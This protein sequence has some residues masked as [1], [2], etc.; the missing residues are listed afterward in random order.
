MSFILGYNTSSPYSKK[1]PK[2][3]YLVGQVNGSR[4]PSVFRTDMKVY[5]NF[6]LNKNAKDKSPMMLQVY[7]DVFN[8]FNTLN[9]RRV[10]RETGNANDDAYLTTSRNEADIE[11][12]IDETAYRNYYSMRLDLNEMYFAPRVVRLGATFT[13]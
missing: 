9:V 12:Q 7:L 6:A 8:L 4:Q 13:F 11:S 10:Y 3:D 1:D 5:R 2:T